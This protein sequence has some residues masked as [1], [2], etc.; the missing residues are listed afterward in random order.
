MAQELR[1]G[2]FSVVFTRLGDAGVRGAG[3][4]LTAL[5][6]VVEKQAKINVSTG[7]HRYGTPTPASPGRGPAVISGNLR[8][9][10]THDRVSRG[11]DGNW[12]TRVGPAA[13]FYPPYPHR[14]RGGGAPHR[15]SSD[16]YGY[17]LEH[18]LR[19]GA[20]Y[21]WLKPAAEFAQ[22]TAEPVIAAAFAAGTW[23]A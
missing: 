20:K 6:Y 8:R 16:K 4:A 7:S 23:G 10:I 1:P 2:A 9:S 19:N 15:T 21:P 18:G 22:R 5:A 12:S 17:Y 13:G 14:G 3:K 11:A